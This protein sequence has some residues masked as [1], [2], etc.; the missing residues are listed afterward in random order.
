MLPLDALVHHAELV[1][2]ARRR[3]VAGE[4]VRVDP[5][6]PELLEAEVDHRSGRLGRDALAPLRRDDPVAELGAA[7]ADE[8]A[9]AHRADQ[10]LGLG[11]AGDREGE[12]AAGAPPVDP[13]RDPALRERDRIRARHRDQVTRDAAIA[14]PRRDGLGIGDAQLAEQQ[15]LGDERRRTRDHAPTIL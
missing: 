4:H 8:A 7:I 14:G 15:A 10:L 9:Q 5:R 1:E 12:P 2:H 11:V 3:E 13:A 6:E